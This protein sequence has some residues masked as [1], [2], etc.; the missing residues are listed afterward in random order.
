MAEQ[1]TKQY[2]D[3]ATVRAE[4]GIDAPA[5][6]KAGVEKLKRQSVGFRGNV[7]KEMLDE[8]VPMVSEDSYNLMK[9]FGMYQQDDRDTR[10]ERKRAGL[11]K[12]W[13]FMIRTKLPGGCA[14][15][16][17]YLILDDIASTWASGSLRITT[18]QTIQFHGVGKLKLQSVVRAL[19]SRL[20][21]SYGACGDVV[22]N[23][24]NCPVADI[25]ATPAYR[26]RQIFTQLT[27]A[28]NARTLPRT[29]A[30]Y[31]IFIN[32]EKDNELAPIAKL[33]DEKEDMYGDSYMPRKFK[34]AVTIP[35]DNCVDVFSNDLG[36]V[37]LLENGVV[38]GYNILAG[39]GLGSSHGNKETYP[40]ICDQ[41]TYV[42]PD[43]VLRAVDAVITIQ[44]DYGNRTN[45]KRARLKYLL[46]EVGT[47][48]FREEMGRR[49]SLELP[50]AAPISDSAWGFDDHLGWHEQIQ[51]GLFY[52][53]LF[54]ENGRISDKNREG[55]PIRTNLRRI[56]EKFRPD[57]RMTGQQN[58]VLANIGE[59]HVAEITKILNDTGISTGNGK[60]STLR[61]N[62]IS[63]V[64][65]PT[66]GL[67]LGEAERVM[68]GVIDKLEEMGFGNERIMI[69][70]S[71]CPN[72]CSRAP[73]SEIGLIARAPGKYNLYIGGDYEGTRLNKL[74]KETVLLDEVPNEIGKLITRW[75][76]EKHQ[77]EEFGDFYHRLGNEALQK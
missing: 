35:Q 36:L 68:P 65:L 48:W 21:T 77:G 56:V 23:V 76:A 74:F 17:Q 22:R 62:E 47:T 33:R 32:G 2:K 53:G 45:R 29:T 15:P 71:G 43:E 54:I 34:I 70:M 8:S 40:R 37:A 51:P 64:S 73:M 1:D 61:R 10:N 38:K 30:F 72:S 24:M 50:E 41:I 9:H 58:I 49:M 44:R 66:C 4:Q 12:D 75:R 14:T 26:G 55:M 60:L 7:K 59:K 46:D 63:C 42:T 52:A 69:R 18:R 11:D 27:N 25:D 20:L 5:E 28:I 39:G 16:D 3:P 6:K 13:S 67:A 19:N 57:V 31:D